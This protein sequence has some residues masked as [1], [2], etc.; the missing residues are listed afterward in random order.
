MH[1]APLDSLL[2]PRLKGVSLL[3]GAPLVLQ[4]AHS[5]I[6]RWALMGGIE[7]VDCAGAFQ[8]LQILHT[9][10]D[11]GLNGWPALDFIQVQRPRT[12]LQFLGSSRILTEPTNHPIVILAPLYQVIASS[13]SPAASALLLDGFTALLSSARSQRSRV[14]IVEAEKTTPIHQAGLKALA[15]AS[16]QTW[17]ISAQGVDCIVNR[18]PTAAASNRPDRVRA[19][20]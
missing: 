6:A 17:R 5:W 2:L 3:T 10:E 15:R 1:I 19:A 7:I 13:S 14:L 4:L 16:Q 11:Q 12:P 18:A 20:M 9:L 8:P